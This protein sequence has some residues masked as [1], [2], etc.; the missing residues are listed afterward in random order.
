LRFYAVACPDFGEVVGERGQDLV[1]GLGPGERPGVLI[2]GGDPGPDVVLQGL[3]R[4]VHA[5]ADQ[6]VGQQ[7]EPALD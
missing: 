5:A 7:A 3:H 6:L 1:G 2:P 4:G